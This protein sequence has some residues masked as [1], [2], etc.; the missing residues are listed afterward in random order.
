M[1]DDWIGSSLPE[2]RKGE[3][4]KIVK[5]VY[6][7][8]GFYTCQDP[9]MRKFCNHQCPFFRDSL[10]ED[11]DTAEK[12]MIERMES[13]RTAINLRDIWNL[14]RD[15]EIE[16]NE[17][18]AINGSTGIGKSA[19]IQNI[20]YNID[21]PTLYFSFEMPSYQL[22]KRFL[23]I[24]SG[25]SKDI[26][27][28]QYKKISDKY[29]K[30]LKHIKIITSPIFANEIPKYAEQTGCKLIVL[31][32]I[33][34]MRSK[35][36]EEYNKISEITSQL[37]QIT[38]KYPLIVIFISQVS[39]ENA[40]SQILD[41]HSGKGS[42][43]IENDSSKVITFNRESRIATTVRIN[44]VKDR[45][46]QHLDFTTSYDNSNLRIGGIPRKSIV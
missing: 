8:E 12:K 42:G 33:G 46:G 28:Y 3:V 37:R 6:S 11:I 15:Y 39:R 21:L 40:K 25:A 10:V 43:S 2:N 35:Y 22:Y 38:I 1:L 20:I 45:E 18:V 31:D 17:L 34:L 32:H 19:F 44:G 24:G 5:D 27:K 16:E 29:K 7:W 9:V 23:Q 4:N 30:N 36:A 14:S 41:I 13:K 26:L